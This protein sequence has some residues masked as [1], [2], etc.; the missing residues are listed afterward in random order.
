MSSITFPH[1]LDD[2]ASSSASLGDSIHSQFYAPPPFDVDGSFQINPL[3]AHPPRTPRSSTS[4]ATSSHSR[5]NSAHFASISVYDEKTDDTET[6]H[7]HSAGKEDAADDDP[8]ADELELDEEDERVRAAEKKIPAHEVWRDIVATSYGRDKAFVSV[9]S[10]LTAVPTST[11][12]PESPA[13]C[14]SSLPP[15]SYQA[16]VPQQRIYMAA[17]PRAPARVYPLRLFIH[18][19]CPMALMH[20]LLITLTEK[21]SFCSTG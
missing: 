1:A 7:G 4:A 6:V 14:H 16:T 10:V 9:R 2:L 18:K 21:C 19:V 13:V 11:A 15:L 20:V 12:P 8:E 3:S 5:P 17:V